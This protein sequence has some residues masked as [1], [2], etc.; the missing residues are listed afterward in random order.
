[1]GHKQR[2]RRE[3][4]DIENENSQGLNKSHADHYG[5][6]SEYSHFGLYRK[7]GSLQIT[8]NGK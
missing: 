4:L 7:E 1:M 2:V 8:K 6:S 3:S 5:S